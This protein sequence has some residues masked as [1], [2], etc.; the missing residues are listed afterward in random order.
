MLKFNPCSN[1]TLIYLRSL[2]SPQPSPFSLHFS[3]NTSDSTPFEVSYLI[4]NFDFSPQSA[5]KLC[6]TYRLG[7]KTTQN[8]DSVLNFFRNHNFSNSQLRNMIAKA[9]WL[10]SCNLSKRLSP[11]FEFFLSK[12]HN[13]SFFGDSNVPQNI[14]LLIENGVADANIARILRIRTRTLQL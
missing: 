11:K 12:A 10:L 1:R 14:R 9:P 5:S 4:H 3:T 6:S 7:F 2:T 13:P 8:P